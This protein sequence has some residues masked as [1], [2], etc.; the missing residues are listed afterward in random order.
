[1]NEDDASIPPEAGAFLRE[2]LAARGR[3]SNVT[4]A[5]AHS[6]QAARC[7][8]ALAKAVYGPD[9]S[10]T[11]RQAELAYLTATAVNNCYY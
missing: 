7:F 5:M 8:S 11:R 6:P 9:S 10:V 2:T 1:L 3:L 4:R